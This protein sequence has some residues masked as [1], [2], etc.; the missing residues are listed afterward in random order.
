MIKLFVVLLLLFIVFNLGRGL[1]FLLKKDRDP[2]AVVKSLTW[3]VGLSL[4]LFI[5]LMVAYYMG[6][7]QPHGI[8]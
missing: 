7:L 1:F 2:V 6:W 3:R 8:I 4:A 5:F